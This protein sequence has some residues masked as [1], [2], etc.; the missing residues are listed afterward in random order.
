MDVD[1]PEVPR[2]WKGEGRI[3]GDVDIFGARMARQYLSRTFSFAAYPGTVGDDLELV[4]PNGWS[5][6]E[7]AR[8]GFSPRPR[9][10]PI[11]RRTRST[12]TTPE[13]FLYGIPFNRRKYS[14]LALDPDRTDP[15]LDSKIDPLVTIR[16]EERFWPGAPIFEDQDQPQYV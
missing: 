9:T 2:E 12:G 14:Y 1:P 7:F 15:E 8:G 5:T 3:A 13:A 16:Q 6:A 11:P 10:S 4:W